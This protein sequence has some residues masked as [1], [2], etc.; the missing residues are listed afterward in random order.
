MICSPIWTC[1]LPKT[2][3]LRHSLVTHVHGTPQIAARPH[4]IMFI[5]ITEGERSPGQLAQQSRNMFSV[6]S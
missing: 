1:E 4:T 2:V 3:T 6:A 5:R